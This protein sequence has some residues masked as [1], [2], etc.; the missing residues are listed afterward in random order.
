MKINLPL[1]IKNPWFWVGIVG[2]MMTAA[3]V[4]KQAFTSWRLVWEG[5][6]SVFMNPVQFSAVVLAVLGVFVDPTTA[7]IED[8]EQA[9]TY[10]EPKR[11]ARKK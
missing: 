11:E 7:G 2:V 5:I 9:L 8:S 1:R 3:G 6:V 10:S 4:D